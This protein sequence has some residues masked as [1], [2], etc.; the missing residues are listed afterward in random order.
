MKNKNVL[1]KVIVWRFLSILVT[2]LVLYL[3]TG[4]VRSATGITVVL[5]SVLV[6]CHFLFEKVWAAKYESR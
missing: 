4:S 3:G 2:L 1:Q 5:H 6:I